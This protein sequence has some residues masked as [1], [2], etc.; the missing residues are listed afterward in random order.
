MCELN[1]LG[2]R[3]TNNE[4]N[5]QT[6]TMKNNTYV[7]HVVIFGSSYKSVWQLWHIVNWK[8]KIK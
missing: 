1:I 3:T 2:D 5:K 8:Q 4:T 7:D 6:K